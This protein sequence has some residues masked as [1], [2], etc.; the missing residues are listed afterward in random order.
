MKKV[1]IYSKY[2]RFWHWTQALLIFFLATTGLEVHG[3][4]SLFGYDKAVTF[5]SNAAWA[6]II[7][8]IFTVFWDFTIGEWRQYIPTLKMMKEQLNYYIFGIFHKAEHPTHKTKY[9]KFNPLQRLTYLGLKLFIIPLMIVTGVLYFYY[10]STL[11]SGTNMSLDWIAYLH[12]FGAFILMGFVIIHVYLTST[13]HTVTSSVKAMITGWEE[14]SD[15]DAKYAIEEG[16]QVKFSEMK[17]EIASSTNIDDLLEKALEHVDEKFGYVNK[18]YLHD[19]TNHAG[20]GYFRIGRN[21]KYEEVNE[22]WLKIYKCKSPEHIIGQTY[23]LNRDPKDKAIVDDIVK[24]VLKGETVH[25]ADLKR[26]CKNGDIGYHT[27]AASPVYDKNGNIN[28][29]EGFI[30]DTTDQHKN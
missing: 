9:T 3:T 8:M 15:E 11:K 21:G 7:L 13:G 18:S 10:F 1:Y 14:M 28:A 25:N 26:V 23:G 30:I 27:L 29:I 6:L 17:A 22:G 24:R 4:F 12:T 16:L 2:N 19:T 5:H 20:V